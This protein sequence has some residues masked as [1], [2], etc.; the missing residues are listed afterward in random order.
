MLIPSGFGQANLKF[1][2]AACPSGAEVTFGF[3]NTAASLGLSAIATAFATAYSDNIRDIIDGD[4]T[5]SAVL[6]KLGPNSTGPSGEFGFA[7]SGTATG[8]PVT[9]NTS[10]LVQKVTASGGRRGRGRSYWPGFTEADVDGG[11]VITSGYL[12]TVQ[13][14]CDGFLADLLAA[15]VP[16]MLLHA[17]SGSPP[18]PDQV[19][20]YV[21]AARMGTQRRRMRR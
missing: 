20:D 7:I 5:L 10:L 17:D 9:P 18:P 21:A 4:A 2:G 19:T 13:A 8:S 12:V 6:V 14:K 11:G 3:D 15:D 16:M 1:T